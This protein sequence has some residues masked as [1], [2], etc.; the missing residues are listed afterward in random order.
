MYTSE[1]FFHTPRDSMEFGQIT[2]TAVA[3]RQTLW[4]LQDTSLDN[5]L[6]I[7]CN[8]RDMISLRI[9]QRVAYNS[10]YIILKTLSLKK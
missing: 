10:K 5:R 7:S 4:C 2:P 9:L 1:R 3:C 6:D 8:K